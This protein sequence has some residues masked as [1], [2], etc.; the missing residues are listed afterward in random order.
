TT[1]V[2][3]LPA[4]AAGSAPAVP[5][6]QPAVEP[7]ANPAAEPPPEPSA[8]PLPPLAPNERVSTRDEVI[9][10]ARDAYARRDRARLAA[11]RGAALAARH[12]LAEWVDYWELRT[13]IVEIGPDEAQ[14]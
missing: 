5:V 6:P 4:D 10:D 2:R 9:R 7:P 12:P 8:E 14:A 3:A 13:R 1:I 11:D